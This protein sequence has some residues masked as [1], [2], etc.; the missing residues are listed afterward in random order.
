MNKSCIQG[1]GLVVCLMTRL[2]CNQVWQVKSCSYAVDELVSVSNN[3]W[4]MNP[5]DW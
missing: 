4:V 1:L 2:A 5:V 3:L